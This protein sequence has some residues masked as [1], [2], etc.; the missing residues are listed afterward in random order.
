MN[1]K[2]IRFWHIAILLA[3]IAS[4][5]LY[6]CFLYHRII[7]KP[8]A[9]EILNI[10]PQKIHLPDSNESG[11]FSIGYAEMLIDPSH[12]QSINF[13]KNTGLICK[14]DSNEIDYLFLMPEKPDPITYEISLQAANELPFKY[15]TIFFSRPGKMFKR[16]KTAEILK[17]SDNFNARGIG[18]F[19]TPDVKG[20]IHFG[21]KKNPGSIIAELFSIDGNIRQLVNVK[22]CS[23][24]KS[25]KALF[26]ILSSYRFIIKD[27]NDENLIENLIVKQFAGNK[28][29]K[30]EDYN[31]T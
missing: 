29:F 16:I 11:L 22:S 28:K 19:E 17:I 20:I 1:K 2:K 27:A 5:N 21:T 6:V 10:E 18:L 9:F 31:G 14:I 8:S 13:Y 15:S 12:F 3:A 30:I 24:E 4:P 7:S 25:K 23:S 26:D